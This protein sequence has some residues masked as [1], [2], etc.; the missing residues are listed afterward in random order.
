[1]KIFNRGLFGIKYRLS[2]EASIL[3][4]TALLGI[5]LWIVVSMAIDFA[6]A[7]QQPLPPPEQAPVFDASIPRVATR[8]ALIAYINAQ[9]ET[10]ELLVTGAELWLEERGYPP[11]YQLLT[12][13]AQANALVADTDDAELLILA[14]AGDLDAMHELAE[15]SL[16]DR[17]DPLEALVW[18][19]RAIVNGSLYAML[20]VADLITTLTDP[21]LAGFVTRPAW[22][23]AVDELNNAT[24]APVERALGWSI[25]AVIMGGYGVLDAAHARR[26]EALTQGLDNPA[27]QRACEIAQQYVLDAASSRRAKGNA[28]FAIDQPPLA[29][30]IDSPATAIPCEAPLAPLVSLETCQ[31]FVFVGPGLRLMNIHACNP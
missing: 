19:D 22:A 28:V 4:A 17:Q 26:I 5:L 11:G 7:P 20:R 21:A 23:A 12:G 27:K 9:N 31:R 3:L 8:Q 24:P 29:L 10:G 2:F 15:R 25:A 30:S 6:N 1:L 16:R 13:N 14:G 18:Y